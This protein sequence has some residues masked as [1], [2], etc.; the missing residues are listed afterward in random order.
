MVLLYL[1]K[2]MILFVNKC[3]GQPLKTAAVIKERG[4]GV[5]ITGVKFVV[6]AFR[7]ILLSGEAETLGNSKKFEFL[8]FI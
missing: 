4:A 5:V 8:E 2:I 6:S 1:A 3:L 7:V